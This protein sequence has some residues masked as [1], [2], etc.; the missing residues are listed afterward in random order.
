MSERLTNEEREAMIAG[1]RAGALDAEEAAEVAFLAALLADPSTW[2]EPSAELEDAVVRAVDEAEPLGDASVTP[3]APAARRRSTSPR[4]RL[5]WSVVAAAA[6]I[7]IALG[8]FGVV[9]GRT[10]T[11][12]E[13]RLSATGLAPGAAATVNIMHNRAGFRVVLDA[14]GLPPLRPGEFYQAWLKNSTDALVPIGSFS[15]SDARVTLWSGVDPAEYSGISVTIEAADNDQRSSGR[16]VLV[17][18]LHAP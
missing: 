8:V 10:S 6:A 5:G 3:I 17:G 7:A 13:S 11:D 2:V 14:H 1:D 16:K 9:H 18:T 12:F 15:S 4:R